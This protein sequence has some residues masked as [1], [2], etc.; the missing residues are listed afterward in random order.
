MS[1]QSLG[2]VL[3]GKLP[4]MNVTGNLRTPIMR[5]GAQSEKAKK[6]D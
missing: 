3:S 6:T 2:D 5:E 4:A 1:V